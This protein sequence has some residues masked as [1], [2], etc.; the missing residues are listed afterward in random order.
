[1][2]KCRDWNPETAKQVELWNFL[3]R[4]SPECVYDDIVE[5]IISIISIPASEASCERSFSRQKRIMGH[6][7]VKSNPDL[8]KA[9]LIL[10][11][12]MKESNWPPVLSRIL[13][14]NRQEKSLQEPY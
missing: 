6:S 4:N 8:L 13:I 9:R 1:V 11:E 7:R 3:V 14:L 2:C 10:K 12:R 5:K